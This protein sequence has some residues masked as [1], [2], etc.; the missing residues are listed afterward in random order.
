VV[1]TRPDDDTPDSA[2]VA[3][4]RQ[5]LDAVAVAAGS[6]A[7]AALGMALAI[8][9]PAMQLIALRSVA[10]TWAGRD[11]EAALARGAQLLVAVRADFQAAVAEEWAFVDPGGFLDYARS[12]TEIAPLVRGFDVL[13]ASDLDAV[14]QFSGSRLS[15]VDDAMYQIFIGAAMESMRRDPAAALAFIE[16]RITGALRDD[17]ILTS[18][19]SVY[20]EV[21]ERAALA[22]ARSLQPPAPRVV[23][24]VIEAVATA[25][26]LRGFELTVDAF[27]AAGVP[28]DQNRTA[29]LAGN[30]AFA[31]SRSGQELRPILN[32]L[33]LRGDTG[34]AEPLV[35]QLL[36][37]WGRDD[38]TAAVEWVAS[39]P[40][41]VDAA[42]IG[43]WLA[44]PVAVGNPVLAAE[45]TD[46]VPPSMRESWMSGIAMV[47]GDL[48]PEG[49]LQWIEKYSGQPGYD[50]AR[51]DVVASV[52]AVNLPLAV[53]YMEE[54]GATASADTLRSF[55]GQWARQ[56]A[57][58][59]ARW[60]FELA[61][62]SRQE[63]A[64]RGLVDRWTANEP[65]A[66]QRWVLEQPRGA[67]RDR[68]LAAMLASSAVG[69]RLDAERLVAAFDSRE[70]AQRGVFAGIERAATRTSP[71]SASAPWT[72]SGL[73][74]ARELLPLLS[75]PDLRARAERLL[76]AGE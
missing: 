32:A 59:A 23:D 35:A 33:A 63:A 20:A 39:H 64:M 76:A 4:R 8:D 67:T 58:E 62:P 70:A 5:V 31:A 19:A 40:S 47:Y 45:L 11:P 2:D 12:A 41:S 50:I 9:D 60:A 74:T 71:A 69:D 43:V 37:N 15:W 27:F 65:A 56:D 68:M 3:R 51:R 57:E 52:T 44:R 13:I 26:V 10:A 34:L 49:A 38:A 46:R 24:A 73:E 1:P 42:S 17:T 61:D 48:D 18:M 36:G 53:R 72:S 21:D 75:D 7:E 14:L 54:T 29:G 66:A 25:D 22:W 16:P 55:A 28:P 30:L 6:D